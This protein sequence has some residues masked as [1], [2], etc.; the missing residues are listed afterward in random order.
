VGGIFSKNSHTPVVP[1]I[2]TRFVPGFEKTFAVNFRM[3]TDS[4][5]HKDVHPPAGGCP[6]LSAFRLE[7]L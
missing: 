7:M 5:R 4:E 6:F 2:R 3:H 1:K